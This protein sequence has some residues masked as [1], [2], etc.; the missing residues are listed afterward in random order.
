MRT[1]SIAQKLH[2]S[3]NT[4]IQIKKATMEHSLNSLN[5][6]RRDRNK[7]NYQ[8]NRKSGSNNFFINRPNYNGTSKNFNETAAKPCPP[9]S[10][11]LLNELKRA[12]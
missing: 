6:L 8:K 4:T 2:K 10:Q 12:K 5:I 1:H 7:N 9:Q 3:G 11:M